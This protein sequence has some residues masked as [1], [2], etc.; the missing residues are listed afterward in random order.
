MAKK[1]TKQLLF[2]NMEKLNPDFKSTLN[3]DAK[4]WHYEW[5]NGWK[6]TIMN[7]FGDNFTWY[8]SEVNDAIPPFHS[9]DWAE[10][11]TFKDAEEDMFDEIRNRI[12]HMPKS[13]ANIEE[14][15]PI[16]KPTVGAEQTQQPAMGQQQA[17]NKQPYQPSDVKSLYNANK[18]ATTVKTAGKR[19][20]TATEFPE[21]FRVWFA[22]LGYKPD[23][24]AISIM[25]VRT[26]VE[27]VMRS[28][29]YK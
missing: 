16:A 17:V 13:Q 10:L 28:M 1:N 4:R 5:G 14:I 25:K 11:K 6:A 15:A 23:N 22:T 27:R 18:T 12:G 8:V 19:I 20:N 2:E 29:G 9:S 26:E 3:E 21:A 24:P 7:A